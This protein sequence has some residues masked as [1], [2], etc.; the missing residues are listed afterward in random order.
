M[1]SA[2][3]PCARRSPVLGQPQDSCCCQQCT[4][5]KGQASLFSF[6]TQTK[7]KGQAWLHRSLHPEA[8]HSL[9]REGPNQLPDAERSPVIPGQNCKSQFWTNILLPPD[10]TGSKMPSPKLVPELG[11]QGVFCMTYT[12]WPQE[13]SPAKLLSLLLSEFLHPRDG[14]QYTKL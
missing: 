11:T 14:P 1:Y 9:C 8:N 10:G 13:G 2:I 6:Y 4:A 3:Q 5:S 7:C 12:G